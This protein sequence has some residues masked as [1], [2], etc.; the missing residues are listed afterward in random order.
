MDPASDAA[1]LSR[2]AGTHAE[3]AF[4]ELVRR[5]VNLVYRAALRQLG[6]DAH[7]AQEVT[8]GVFTL[9]AR[10]AASLTRHPS[11]AGWLYTSTHFAVR[12]LRRSERRRLVREQEAFTMH[13]LTTDTA[14]SADWEK[15]RPV[16]D[17]AMRQ[18]SE[19]DREALL[20]R[21]FEAQP[22]AEVGAKLAL[23]ED[24]ARM[25]VERSLGKL[26]GLL[27]K[28][29]VTS[30]AV[31]I[32][33]MLA[34]EASIAA[35]AG[36]AATVTGSALSG[37]TVAGG[38]A[39]ALKVFSFMST[40]KIMAGVTGLVI[41]AATAITL[42]QEHVNTDLREQVAT[43]RRAN[44]TVA[45][46]REE[47]RRVLAA[48]TVARDT[49]A[50]EHDELV[51][52]RAEKAAYLKAVEARQAAQGRAGGGPAVT[53]A[54]G[55]SSS[56]APGMVSTEFMANVG[57]ATPSAA[58]QTIAWG[59][60]EADYNA[61]AGA[62]MF[63]PPD[64]EKLE[65]F[66]ATLPEK[67]RTQY[68]TPEQIVALVMAGSPKPIAAVQLLGRSQPDADTEIHRVQWQYQTGEVQQNEL[69]FHREA[70]GWKQV[71]APAMVDRVITF[72]KA[73]E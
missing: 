9:L 60:R 68:G 19:G 2:Y 42:K 63:D 71:V 62:L 8:Q 32:G 44:A 67:M 69:K 24:A 21:F 26:H 58:A 13:E 38:G 56:L 53:G 30:T 41:V 66:I 50:A 39:V 16:L 47:N 52:L 5:H 33:L 37:A 35:P 54:K 17:D 23:S 28:R 1:L 43:L 55:E 20:L 57:R 72:L 70:D 15:L 10:K 25:R 40:T 64:R 45:D 34:N 51:K 7:R 46:V 29:G 12:D 14:D 61:V 3:E 27:A 65:A 49:A 22:F 48:Q 73:K 11:L 18:L 36:L 59:L 31:A 4:A 6:G